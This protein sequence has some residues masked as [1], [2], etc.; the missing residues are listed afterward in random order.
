MLRSRRPLGCG[1][2]SWG[3]FTAH[4][5]ENRCLL[6]DDLWPYGVE[7]N[8]Q[9]LDTFLRNHHEQGLSRRRVAVEELFAPETLGD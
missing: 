2:A 5:E 1:W 3:S 4:R 8:R 9:V 7:H 6:S